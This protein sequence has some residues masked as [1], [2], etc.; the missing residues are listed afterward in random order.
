MPMKVNNENVIS[1]VTVMLILG[2]P[3]VSVNKSSDNNHCFIQCSKG[4]L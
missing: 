2:F 1:I 3:I 4:I